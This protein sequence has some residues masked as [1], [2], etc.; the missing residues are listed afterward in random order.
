ME[1]IHI[2]QKSKNLQLFCAVCDDVTSVCLVSI[3]RKI[4]STVSNNVGFCVY[5]LSSWQN[6]N[7]LYGWLKYNWKSYLYY[8]NKKS[9]Y[10]FYFEVTHL[11]LG[12]KTQ[13]FLDALTKKDETLIW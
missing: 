10:F 11:C 12:W 2:T 7:S 8:H 4:G 13:T 5:R 3:L 9:V 1:L 6:K